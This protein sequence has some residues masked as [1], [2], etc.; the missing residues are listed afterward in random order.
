VH[1]PARS[2]LFHVLILPDL[3]RVAMVL[4][5]WGPGDPDVRGAAD[6]PEVDRT[7]G[8]VVFGLLAEM[9]RR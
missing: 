3:K 9:E 8:A 4:F 1:W 7:A 5:H 2:E 6:R